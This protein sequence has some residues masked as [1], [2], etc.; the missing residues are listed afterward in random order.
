MKKGRPNPVSLAKRVHCG[1]KRQYTE[2]QAKEVADRMVR[3]GE[4]YISH[5]KCC[6]CGWYHV[7]HTPG[8]KRYD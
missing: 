5:Y 3:Q 2:E 6:H 8:Y 4:G 7:G 1:R